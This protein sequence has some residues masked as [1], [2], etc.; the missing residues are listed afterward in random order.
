MK[1]T[2]RD[3]VAALAAAGAGGLLARERL[4]GGGADSAETDENESSESTT[5]SETDTAMLAAV[6]RAVYPSEVTGIEEFV[7]TY[8][9]G[10]IDRVRND[11]Y[12][13]GVSE[14]LEYVDDRA[15]TWYGEPYLELD[16][17][18]QA[19]V[20]G[21]IG[22]DRADPAPDGTDAERVRHFV[23]NE[24]LF[25]LYASPTGGELV[26]LENPQGYPGGLDSYQRG[27]DA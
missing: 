16:S 12:R 26:G 11:A 20:L 24:V 10:R 2:R 9:R 15:R 3:A 13:G 21:E 5:L 25:A 8:S 6:A 18:T 7:E 4:H 14:A 19:S 23:V 27:P 1:L 17:E 22:A